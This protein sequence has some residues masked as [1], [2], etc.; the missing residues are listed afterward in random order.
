[1]TL[2][3]APFFS[4]HSAIDQTTLHAIVEVA[5]PNDHGSFA[6]FDR[7]MGAAGR[8]LGGG[9]VIWGQGTLTAVWLAGYASSDDMFKAAMVLHIL[10]YFTPAEVQLEVHTRGLAQQLELV[11]EKTEPTTSSGGYY[12]GYDVFKPLQEAQAEGRWAL[13]AAPK[14]GRGFEVA[15]NVALHGLVQA[16]RLRFSPDWRRDGH[17]YWHVA[18]WGETEWHDDAAA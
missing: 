1:M 18:A 8:F 3:A 16:A 5:R 12:K 14:K 10:S 17:P 7:E 9:S 11:A 4:P 2:V 6:K 13:Q 15:R